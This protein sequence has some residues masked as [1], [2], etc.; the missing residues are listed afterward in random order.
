MAAAFAAS[1]AVVVD[2]FAPFAGSVAGAAVLPFVSAL[3]SHSVALDAGDP[4]PVSGIAW[5]A[6]VGTSDPF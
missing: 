4:V 3:H 6:V 1:A 2:V 5:P